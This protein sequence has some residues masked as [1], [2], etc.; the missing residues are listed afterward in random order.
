[1]TSA[2]DGRER[3]EFRNRPGRDLLAALA[4]GYL[5]LAIPVLIITQS[6]GVL[7]SSG[8]IVVLVP[9]GV[10]LAIM[11]ADLNAA[12]ALALLVGVATTFFFRLPGFVRIPLLFALFAGLYYCTLVAGTVLD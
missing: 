8:L 11:K 12:L 6:I 7:L 3:G 10:I 5:A 2:T 9:I 4:L 1:L